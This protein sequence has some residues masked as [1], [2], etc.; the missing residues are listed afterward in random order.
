MVE[1]PQNGLI[2]IIQYCFFF[3]VEGIHY[4]YYIMAEITYLYRLNCSFNPL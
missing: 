4:C 3:F 2:P 1:N